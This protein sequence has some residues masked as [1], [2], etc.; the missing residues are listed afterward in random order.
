VVAFMVLSLCVTATGT[1]RFAVAMGYDARWGYLVGAIF[2][3]AKT[4]LP[5]ALLALLVR[6]A[7]C[8]AAL[9]GIYKGLREGGN[10]PSLER[11]PPGC[12]SS[13]TAAWQRTRRPSLGCRRASVGPL[14]S[15]GEGA[16]RGGTRAGRKLHVRWQNKVSLNPP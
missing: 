14:P 11:R 3:V 12:A 16:D 6:G 9:L 13:P 1:A 2:D 7:F 15:G 10:E 4:M 5:V 8:T